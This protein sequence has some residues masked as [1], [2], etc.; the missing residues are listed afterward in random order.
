MNPLKRI[1]ILTGIACAA[2]CTASAA[3]QRIA[4]ERADAVYV[5][6]LNA[7]LTR[8]LSDGIFPAISPN[9]KSVA[10]TVV[11]KT[12]SAYVRHI[13]VMEIASGNVRILTEIPSDNVYYAAW[14]PDSNTIAFTMFVSGVWNLALIKADGTDFKVIKKG[15]QDKVTLFSPCWA[16]DGK[17]LFCQDMTTIYRITPDGSVVAQWDIETIIPNGAMS[18]DGR[19]D[20]SPDGHRLLLS[21]DMDEEYERKDWDGPVPALWSFDV[22]TAAAVR[23]TTKNLFAWDGCWLNNSDLLFVSQRPGEKQA[24]I[25]QSNGKELKRLISDAKRPSV[26]RQ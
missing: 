18:G 23:L 15:D 13:A 9:G 11:D 2:V 10:F 5:S 16:A 19:I 8:K 3:D 22:Q 1:A 4:F 14:S 20:V 12:S 25:Y 21:V 7:S 17:S 6:N 26:S 24:A